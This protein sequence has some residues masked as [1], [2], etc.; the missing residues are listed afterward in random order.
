VNGV[1]TPV[2]DRPEEVF[3]GGRSL[4]GL[5]SRLAAGFLTVETVAHLLDELA[6]R[7]PVVASSTRSLFTP[8]LLRDTL[9]CLVDEGCSIANLLQ[10]CEAL[11]AVNRVVDPAVENDR[12]VFTAPSTTIA[13]ARNEA[14]A[15]LPDALAQVARERLRYEILVANVAEEFALDAKTGG[16]SPQWTMEVYLL[17]P[18]VEAFINRHGPD[19]LDAEAHQRLVTAIADEIET[20]PVKGRSRA[21][22]LTNSFTRPAVWRVA[23]DELTGLAVISYRD[24]P[25]EANIKPLSRVSF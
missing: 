11:L 9:R 1:T 15:R 14:E 20:R 4:E 16:Y 25:P 19:G 3:R 8:D 21:P 5:L 13:W 17:D 18:K 2:L 24:L 7:R 22:I 6:T 10:I 12:I 23:R